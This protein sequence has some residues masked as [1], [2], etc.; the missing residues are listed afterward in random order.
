MLKK[1]LTRRT[2]WSASQHRQPEMFY[3]LWTVVLAV[4]CPKPPRPSGFLIPPPPP[5]SHTCYFKF[6]FGLGTNHS[7]PRYVN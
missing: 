3:V 1:P 6:I 4:L 5:N 7:L 2:E